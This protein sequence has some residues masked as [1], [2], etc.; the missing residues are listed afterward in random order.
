MA[1]SV[2]RQYQYEKIFDRKESTYLLVREQQ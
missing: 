2:S 1:D